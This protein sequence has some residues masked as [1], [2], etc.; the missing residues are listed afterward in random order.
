MNEL[1][2]WKKIGNSKHFGAFKG[3]SKNAD[4]YILS[5]PYYHGSDLSVLIQAQ[6]CLNIVDLRFYSAGIILMLQRLHS[7]R[8]VHRN[9]QP[10]NIR[11]KANGYLLLDNFESAKLLKQMNENNA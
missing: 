7:L 5:Y 9:L 11:I 1:E 6:G 2:V 10:S 3:A 8:I 4:S